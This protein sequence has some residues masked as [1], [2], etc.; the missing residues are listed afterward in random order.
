MPTPPAPNFSVVDLL[1]LPPFERE[2]FLHIARHG[3][4]D[5]PAVAEA[6][7]EP[8]QKVREAF[9]SLIRK[10]RIRA[11]PDG[12]ADV[13]LGHV[14]SRTTLPAQMWPA[15][16]APQRLYSEQEIATLITAIPILQFARARMSEFADHG[17]SHALRV[18]SFATQLGYVLG[19]T[20]SERQLLRVAALFHDIGNIVERDRHHIISQETVQRL[21]ASGALPFAPKEIELI[22]LLCRWHRRDYDPERV[23]TLRGEAVRTGLVASILRVADA[24][25]ID[26]RRSDYDRRSRQLLEFFFPDRLPYWTSLEEILGVRIRCAPAAAQAAPANQNEGQR[27]SS[28]TLQVLTRKPTVD[29]PQIA[30]LRRDLATTPLDWSVQEVP[31]SGPAASPPNGGPARKALLVLPFDSHSLVMTAISRRH[32]QAAGYQ[33]DLMCYPDTAD[34]PGWLWR[35]ALAETE[36]EDIE[37]LIVIDDRPDPDV[38]PALMNTLHRWRAAGVGVSILNRHEA[39]WS[40]LPELLQLGVEV[41]LGGDWAYFWGDS[42]SQEDLAWGRI[43]A[44]CARDHTLAAVRASAREQATVRG[45]LKVV[46][47]VIALKP[48]GDTAGWMALA[49]LVLDRIAAN[50]LDYFARQ[51]PAFIHAYATA[52]APSQ[53]KGRVVYFDRAP[54]NVP[55]SYYWILEAAIEH[56]GGSMERGTRFSVPYAM[57]VWPQGDGVE[58]LAISHWREDEATPIRLLYPNDLGPPPVGTESTIHVRLPAATAQLVVDKLLEA[59]NHDA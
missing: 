34:A 8:V 9:N 21:A 53:V 16:L 45:L 20:E 29:N 4:A 49:E 43:A 10:G 18:K 25:D 58:L 7:D 17:P 5:P 56:Y 51:A 31:L 1:D 35:Q 27:P 59:C 3:P 39:N 55:Q 22:G 11:L 24:M 26:S 46:Y 23:D 30:M 44:L 28:V 54:G 40:L 12:R 13:A 50:D 36:T 47:D 38:T 2:V 6:I 14:G 57:A 48:A 32:L 19:L 37:R 15:L 52:D 33:V 42:A 41:T